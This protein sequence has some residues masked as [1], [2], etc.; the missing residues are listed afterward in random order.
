MRSID[1]YDVSLLIFKKYA[2][3]ICNS[4][5]VGDFIRIKSELIDETQFSFVSDEIDVGLFLSRKERETYRCM[6]HEDMNGTLP[7]YRLDIL[8]KVVDKIEG[9]PIF[10]EVVFF[11]TDKKQVVDGYKFNMLTTIKALADDIDESI[12]YGDIEEYLKTQ[13]IIDKIVMDFCKLDDDYA[14]SLVLCSEFIP[15]QREHENLK[16]IKEDIILEDKR[17]KEINKIWANEKR[18]EKRR[19][20]ALLRKREK[21]T[22]EQLLELQIEIDFEKYL[23]QLEIEELFEQLLEN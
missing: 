15:Y 16:R 11:P 2:E 20:K 12:C 21:E 3:L 10:Q 18:K 1:T 4:F 14:D 19:E 13:Q 9:V 5:N 17:I 22:L 23:E 8:Y 7:K 6:N